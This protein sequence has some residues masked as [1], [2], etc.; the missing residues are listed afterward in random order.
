M[1]CQWTPVLFVR[2]MFVR[3]CVCH[4]TVNECHLFARVAGLAGPGKTATPAQRELKLIQSKRDIENP[5]I[6]VQ[7]VPLS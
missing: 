5:S 2:D 7:A 6:I 3:A 1:I 4:K